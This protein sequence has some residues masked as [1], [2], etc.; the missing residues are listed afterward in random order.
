MGGALDAAISRV[1]R[2]SLQGSGDVAQVLAEPFPFDVK[3]D[4]DVSIDVRR[5]EGFLGASGKYQAAF[6]A[7]IEISTTGDDA[8]VVARRLYVAPDAAWDGS[9]F[10]RLAS[11]LSADASALAGEILAALPPR[12]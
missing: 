8:K 12:G 2:T 1:L 7:V 11:L 9:D 3:R 4:Y 10:N 6:S 5:C